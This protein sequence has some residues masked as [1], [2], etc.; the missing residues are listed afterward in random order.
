MVLR[1]MEYLDQINKDREVMRDPNTRFL[2]LRSGERAIIQFISDLSGS[3][4][5]NAWDS[6]LV[7]AHWVPKTI[8]DKGGGTRTIKTYAMCFARSKHIAGNELLKEYSSNKCTYCEEMTSEDFLS[9]RVFF[10]VYVKEIWHKE[11]NPRLTANTDEN[12]SPWQPKKFGATQT[13]YYVE[14]VEGTRILE[15]SKTFFDSLVEYYNSFGSLLTHLYQ[16]SRSESS[17]GKTSYHIMN[18][19]KVENIGK[20]N[21]IKASLPDLLVTIA[22]KSMPTIEEE[23]KQKE[24][25][26]PPFEVDISEPQVYIPASNEEV[27][28][29][30]KDLNTDSAPID[31]LHKKWA[32]IWKGKEKSG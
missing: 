27:E 26:T 12:I 23:P 15:Q 24:D 13:I 22:K 17:Q 16:Y 31:A 1:G 2:F 20:V 3:E 10:W 8:Q 6:V 7:Q 19:E 5:R 14:T 9:R 18:Y 29:F 28:E 4:P 25:T 30:K 32:N 11:Q 21:E